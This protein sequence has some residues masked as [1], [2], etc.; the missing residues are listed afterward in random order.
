MVPHQFK[1]KMQTPRRR[2]QAAIPTLALFVVC[3]Y[4]P[5]SPLLSHQ[6]PD[7]IKPLAAPVSSSAVKTCSLLFSVWSFLLHL[8]HQ[9]AIS[10]DFH[11]KY[12]LFLA[13]PLS[14]GS[15]RSSPLELWQYGLCYNWSLQQMVS[16]VYHHGRSSLSHLC[17]LCL[18]Q[19][20]AY[21][22]CSMKTWGKHG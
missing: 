4:P 15:V 9:A 2:A 12:I 8:A 19:F 10:H 20:L 14:L 3:C 7:T 6:G 1:G 13:M 18:G 5:Q 11:G 16:F 17:V 21:N 22:R